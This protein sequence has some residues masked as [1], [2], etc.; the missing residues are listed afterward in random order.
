MNTVTFHDF[1]MR[2]EDGM[3]GVRAGRLC[4]LSIDKH[5]RTRACLT[6]RR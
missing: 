6:R 3:A 2:P 1:R 4:A 5:L